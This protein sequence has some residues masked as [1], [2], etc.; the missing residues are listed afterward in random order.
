MI[1]Y[2]NIDFT[3]NPIE[4]TVTMY[5][6]EGNSYQGELSVVHAKSKEILD[7]LPAKVNNA[8]IPGSLAYIT[9]ME[10]VWQKDFDGSWV[11]VDL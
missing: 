5:D 3:V 10:D 8:I 4:Q 7:N 6:S 1:D 9:G 11:G 2:S